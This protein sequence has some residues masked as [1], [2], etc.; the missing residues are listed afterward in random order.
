MILKADG[1]DKRWEECVEWDRLNPQNGIT[2]DG[3]DENVES[4]MQRL[5]LQECRI[6]DRVNQYAA[7]FDGNEVEVKIDPAEDVQ[8]DSNE[9]EV[10]IDAA[11]DVQFDGNEVEVGRL[12][13]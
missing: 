11:E 5:C 7:Q 3:F 6:L 8:F 10:G 1:F 9:V 4:S 2:D 13:R 12:V